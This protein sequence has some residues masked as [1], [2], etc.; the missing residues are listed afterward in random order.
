MLEKFPE[1]LVEG[2]QPLTTILNLP[3]ANDRHVL[4][5]AIRCGAQHIVTENLKDFPNG[6][7]EQFGVEPISADE[8]LSRTA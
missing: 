6:Y 4:A 1:S 2:Y 7:L 5:A 8:F 3:D